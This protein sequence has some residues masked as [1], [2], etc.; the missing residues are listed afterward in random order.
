MVFS[1]LFASPYRWIHGDWDK[2]AYRDQNEAHKRYL[3][4]VDVEQ[5]KQWEESFVRFAQTQHQGL[6]EG[7]ETELRLTDE[8]EA[9]LKEAIETFNATWN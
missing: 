1:T 8:L 6:I 3:D 9:R 5:V 7:I 2:I 4:Q